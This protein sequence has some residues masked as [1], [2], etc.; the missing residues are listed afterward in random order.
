MMKRCPVSIVI[1]LALSLLL[2]LPMLGQAEEVSA[3]IVLEKDV[4]FTSPGGNDLLVPAGTYGVAGDGDRLRLTGEHEESVLVIEAEQGSHDQSSELPIAV[5]IQ[6]EGEESDEIFVGLLMP[7]RTSVEATGSL[8]G[9]RSRGFRDRAQQ[10]RQN[11]GQALRNAVGNVR[12]RVPQVAVAI[13]KGA[14]RTR[15]A[16]LP[17]LGAARAQA[18]HILQDRQF[19]QLAQEAVR[20]ILRDKADVIQRLVE[21]ARFLAS[22]ENR[23]KITSLLSGERICERPFQAIMGGIG[24]V[25]ASMPRPR[26]IQ[27]SPAVPGVSYTY[28]VGGE[29]EY[30]VG[31]QGA[32]GLIAGMPATVTSQVQPDFGRLFWSLG[33]TVVTDI[34]GSGGVKAG[35]SFSPPPQGV[36]NRFDLAVKAGGDTAVGGGVNLTFYFA[37]DSIRKEWETKRLKSLI[38][39]LDGIEA[40]ILASASA[41][42]VTLGLDI[43]YT[44][45]T[46]FTW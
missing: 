32:I 1:G 23:N 22:P 13:C 45:V 30:I 17:I 35:I 11:T 41:S 29:A 42:P 16:M 19:Q 8:S 39:H 33:G 5:T 43:G 26:A 24:Q 14:L 27:P 20:T 9:V 18:G 37:W 40:A 10:F 34:G 2:G 21:E 25:Y 44:R 28:A 12:E 36:E 3:R 38:P 15:P 46:R 31:V 6:G 7:D 4:H